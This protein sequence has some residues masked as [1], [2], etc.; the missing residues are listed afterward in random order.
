MVIETAELERIKSEVGKTVTTGKSYVGS[1]IYKI[2]YKSKEDGRTMADPV[3]ELYRERI[4]KKDWKK[5]DTNM[6]K[7]ATMINGIFYNILR[8]SPNV[9]RAFEKVRNKP[10]TK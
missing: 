7:N 5:E 4:P 8:N 6:I 9:R 10:Q 1:E 2:Y 3:I